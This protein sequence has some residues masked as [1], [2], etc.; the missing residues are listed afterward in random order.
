MPIPE[1]RYYV[2]KLG[3]NLDGE[4]WASAWNELD[5]INWQM[6]QPGDAILIDGGDTGLGLIRKHEDVG[7]AG[8]L[9]QAVKLASLECPPVMALEQHGVAGCHGLAFPMRSLPHHA[10]LAEA[11]T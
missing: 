6:V 2:S 5:Q 9:C 3:S 11:L 7:R 1:R 8:A 10:V 4:S